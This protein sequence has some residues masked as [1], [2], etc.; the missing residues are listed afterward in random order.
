MPSKRPIDKQARAVALAA[1]TGPTDAA[2]QTGIPQQT[3]SRWMAEMPEQVNELVAQRRAAIMDNYL[4]AIQAGTEV[5][6]RGLEALRNGDTTL[7]PRDLQSVA[8]TTGIFHD[9]LNTTQAGGTHR[10]GNSTAP[11]TWTVVERAVLERYEQRTGEQV[12]EHRT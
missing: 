11:S 12:L 7:T 8:V 5:V 6:R 9:K 3:I 4:A 1:L 2:R 10:F